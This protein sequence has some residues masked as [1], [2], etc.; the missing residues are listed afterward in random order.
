MTEIVSDMPGHFVL[1]I[2][3]QWVISGQAH[4]RTEVTP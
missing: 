3:R 1:V 4:E 2:D